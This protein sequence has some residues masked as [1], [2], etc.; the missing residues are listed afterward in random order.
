MLFYWIMFILPAWF[1]LKEHPVVRYNELTRLS[2]GSFWSILFVLLSFAI[3]FRYEVGGDWGSYQG[4]VF[5]AATQ[6]LGE[7]LSNKEPAYNLLNWVGARFGGVYFTN[8]ACGMIFSWGLISFCKAQLRPWLALLV[9]VPYLITV[10]SMGYSRQAV[11]IGLVMFGVTFLMQVRIKPFVI[12]VVFAS[13]F[14]QTA[15]IVLPIALFVKNKH[16]GLTIFGVMLSTITVYLLTLNN[17]MSA[18]EHGY[19][20]SDYASAGA[21]IRVA[22]NVIPAMLFLLLRKRFIFLSEVQYTFWYWISLFSFI[23]V[24]LLLFS[25]SSVA[26]DRLALYCIPLQ[27]AAWS[28]LP[29]ALAQSPDAKRYWILVVLLYN[30]MVLFVWLNF[31]DHAMF[32]I[33]Y[34]FYPW[35]V[36]WQ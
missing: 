15:V 28:N 8:V 6:E 27:L 19:L 20:D 9:S 35:E 7:V 21:N 11:A 31:A 29:D 36:L 32:W 22:M 34:K 25:V 12:C 23:F 2:W 13:L 5:I 14:H 33:P 1:A 24:A 16:R 3:G 10:V 26:V 4:R 17:S 30:A 18:L